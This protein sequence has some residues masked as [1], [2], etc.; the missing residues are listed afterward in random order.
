MN[1]ETLVAGIILIGLGFLFFFNNKNIAKGAYQFYQKI[2]TEH[3][4]KF[5]FRA[6]AIILFAGGLILISRAIF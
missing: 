1:I 2:Y 5:M 4:L 3:N 6:C